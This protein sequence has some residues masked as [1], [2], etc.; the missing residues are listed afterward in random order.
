MIV[1]N[2]HIHDFV[3]NQIKN[4]NVLI[5]NNHILD[6]INYQITNLGQI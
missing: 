4:M 6:L 5:N 1:I 3:V 2:K